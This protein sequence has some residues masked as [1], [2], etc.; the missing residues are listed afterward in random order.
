MTEFF[1]RNGF[2]PVSNIKLI[3]VVSVMDKE[4]WVAVEAASNV[5][6]RI[7]A[8]KEEFN[9]ACDHIIQLLQDAST[10]L[11]LGSHA[12]A[13]FLAITAIEETSKAHIGMFRNS[14]QEVARGKDPLYRHNQKHLLA[15][16]PTV[17]MGERLQAAIGE[18]RMK[19]LI[20]LARDGKLVGLRES[21][22]YFSQVGGNL[23]TPKEALQE[24][25]ARELLLL[26]IE[27]FVDG[28]V[29]YT[30]HTFELGKRT[31]QIFEKWAT[32]HREWLG[33]AS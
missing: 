33:D 1:V 23:I 3:D 7:G 12:S 25:T 31:D 5:G 4:W 11:E 9:S 32:I 16:G 2:L 6:T 26:A 21:A 29:G 14:V 22:L 19:E 24:Q 27:A 15:L 17:E 13:A 20:Q 10:L 18:P 8:S 28:L 30:D